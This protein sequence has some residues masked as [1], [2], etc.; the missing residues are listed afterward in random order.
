MGLIK[1]S[2]SVIQ[3]PLN[4]ARRLLRP[5]NKFIEELGKNY[6]FEMVVGM[7]GQIL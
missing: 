2:G 3:M 6:K 1:V 7:N 4:F 5:N